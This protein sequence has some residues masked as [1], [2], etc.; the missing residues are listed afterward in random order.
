ML[1]LGLIISFY[2]CMN[3]LCTL[4][5]V[6]GIWRF[7]FWL[8]GAGTL[9]HPAWAPGTASHPLR[10]FF[11]WLEWFTHIYTNYIHLSIRGSPSVALQI[12]SLCN[13][14]LSGTLSLL[15]QS[16]GSSWSLSSVFFTVGVHQAPPGFLLLALWPGISFK[17]VIWGHL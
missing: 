2:W 13:S 17:A 4:L 1:S 9:F 14:L 6:S 12:C 11:S 15:F 3:F 5:N 8:E 10:W 7:P 16:P